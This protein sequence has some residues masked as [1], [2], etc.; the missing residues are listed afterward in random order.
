MAVPKYYE[1]MDSTIEAL[2][3]LGGSASITELEE[4][5]AAILGLSDNDLNEIHSGNR[6]KFSYRL[7]WTRTYLKLYGLLENSERGI[8]AL[9]PKGSKDT[10]L[11]PKEIVRWVKELHK[12]KDDGE[13]VDVDK[14]DAIAERKL[15]WREELL[16]IIQNIPPASF[17]RL[18]QRLLRE[19]GF[20]HVEVTG[21]SGDGG[22]DGKGVVKIGGLLSFHV[23]FQ[24]KRYKGSV[25]TSTVRDFRG[26]MVGRAD[27]GLLIS[28]G[29]FTR[30]ARIEAQRDGAPP[31]DLIDGDELIEK[32]KSLSIGLFIEEKI[33]EIVHINKD[34]YSTL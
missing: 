8:W 26:A 14:D 28:T 32:L 4:T 9:T 23:I 18:C 17:E 24:C 30:D 34:W 3:Q 27:K 33:S 20:I 13:S 6:T 1:M 12:S 2:K 16:N 31:I 15:T 25:S 5:I 19:S 22:I 7:A 21:R 11:D 29:T 10:K